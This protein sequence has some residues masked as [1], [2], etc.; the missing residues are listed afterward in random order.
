MN[1]IFFDT[2]L[3]IYLATGDAEMQ[4]PIIRICSESD[5]SLI[6]IQVLNEFTAVCLK[7]Q[8]LPINK[9]QKYVNEYNLCFEVADVNFRNISIAFDIKKKYNYAW[10]DCLI[11]ATALLNDCSIL[12]TQDMQHN[13]IIEK[14]LNIINPFV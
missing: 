13:Q 12:Y 1:K 11:I 3:L 8:L 6:S 5:F 2:N 9:I 4:E 10:Y 14:K 7:K